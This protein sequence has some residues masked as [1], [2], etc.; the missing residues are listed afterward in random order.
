MIPRN[1]EYHRYYWHRMN[2]PV[3][4]CIYQYT[5]FIVSQNYYDT[6]TKIL[7]YWSKFK[8][9]RSM[10]SV[11]SKRNLYMRFFILSEFWFFSTSKVT[12]ARKME[13]PATAIIYRNMGNARNAKAKR[14]GT[15]SV[16]TKLDESCL[17]TW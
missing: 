3:V 8:L 14:H 11:I 13:I 2:D 16:R 6:L 1:R 7:R 4:Q 9:E 10:A 12:N 17:K 5:F 15:I